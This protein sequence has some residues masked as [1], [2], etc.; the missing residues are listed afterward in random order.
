[1]SLNRSLSTS[2]NGGQRSTSEGDSGMEDSFELSKDDDLAMDDV[3]SLSDDT[4][5]GLLDDPNLIRLCMEEVDK[6]LKESTGTSLDSQLS[7]ELESQSPFAQTPLGQPQANA[8]PVPI[9]GLMPDMNINSSFVTLQQ[10]DQGGYFTSLNSPG[11]VTE[12]YVLERL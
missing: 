6:I 9:Q 3:N 7:E 11:A 1:M 2:T 8:V 4:S 5:N 10:H 12:R